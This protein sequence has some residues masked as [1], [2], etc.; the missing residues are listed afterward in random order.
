MADPMPCLIVECSDAETW[1]AL[2]TGEPLRVAGAGPVRIPQARQPAI[3]QP[4][5]ETAEREAMRLAS[6][7]GAGKVFVIFEAVAAAR[8]VTIHSYTTLG[9]KLTGEQLLPRVLDL[10]EEDDSIP[11]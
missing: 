10:G 4:D 5:R 7:K 8:M 3:L 9:G 11:F 6:A 2:A 1:P